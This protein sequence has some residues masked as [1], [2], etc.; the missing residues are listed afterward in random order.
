MVKFHGDI[1][2]S[3]D[4]ECPAITKRPAMEKEF[5][6]VGAEMIWKFQGP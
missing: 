2:K 5:C 1:I 6:R 3:N 4:S